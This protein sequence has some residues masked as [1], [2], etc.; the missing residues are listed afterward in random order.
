MKIAYCDCFSGLSGD[1]FAGALLD[2]GLP[3]EEVQRQLAGLHLPEEVRLETRE[4]H[5]GALRARSFEVHAAHEPHGHRH[6]ADIYALI[7]QSGLSPRA[8]H[9]S[10]M[11]F[12]KLAQ[13][14][15][16]VHGIA[17]ENVHFHEVGAL[18]SIVDILTAAIGL[19]YF[20]IERLYASALPLGSGQIESQHGLLPLPAPATLE[21]LRMANAPTIPSNATVELITPTGAAIL[22]A[23]AT[24]EQPALRITAAGTGAGQR[25]LPWPNVFRLILGEGAEPSAAVRAGSGM[26][27]METN[28]DDMN[29]EIFDHVMRHLFSAGALDV[30]LTTITMKKNRPAAMLSV[31]AR[32]EHEAALA[33]LI[34]RETSTFGLRVQPIYRYEA[35]RT[36]R[37]VQTAYGEV[38]LKLKLLNGQVVQMAP[39]YEVCARLADEQA[40][41][42]M[43][44][45][46][47]ALLAGEQIT[48][49]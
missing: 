11:I 49:P 18:D 35:E 8:Q 1:M 12:E 15:A 34:L 42:V 27:V 37:S 48:H 41:P 2:A 7:E 29:P 39:E 40:V 46:R 13:A 24:F 3:L 4:T 21:L 33:D 36:F 44:I 23:L 19:E 25:D 32:R 30:Y 9:T 28:I 26:V 16:R 17:V 20:G 14:E 43:E 6:P 10:R 38:T 47:A 22:A 5:K 45:Y 31:I